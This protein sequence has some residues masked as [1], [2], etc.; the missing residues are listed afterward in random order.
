MTNIIPEA[1]QVC[2]GFIAFISVSNATFFYHTIYLKVDIVIQ[3]I[4][5]TIHAEFECTLFVLFLFL[6]VLGRRQSSSSPTPAWRPCSCRNSAFSWW[7]YGNC[8]F[9]FTHNTLEAE[10]ICAY[11]PSVCTSLSSM[12]Q[13]A[14]ETELSMSRSL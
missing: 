8:C 9:L 2:F 1:P 4:K 6:C 7:Q 10:Y 3:I 11:G 13:C 14:N 5:Y 12:I